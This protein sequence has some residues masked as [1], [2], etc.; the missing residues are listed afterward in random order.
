MPSISFK[1]VKEVERVSLL[2][3]DKSVQFRKVK[4]GNVMMRLE[5]LDFYDILLGEYKK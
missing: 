1:P 3:S 5:G 4:G 2:G